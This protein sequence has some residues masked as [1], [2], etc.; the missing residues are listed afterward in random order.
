MTFQFENGIETLV[1]MH[2]TL[3]NYICTCMNTF[4]RCFRSFQ[5]FLTCRILLYE[6]EDSQT[7]SYPDVHDTR[8]RYCQI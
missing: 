3:Q 4:L 2:V 7:V 1:K 6:H 5:H 8:L